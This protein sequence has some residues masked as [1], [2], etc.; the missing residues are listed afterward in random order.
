MKITVR[1]LQ[2]K[3][4]VSPKEI[5]KIILNVLLFERIKKR[6]EITVCIVEDKKI[7]ELNRKFLGKNEAT[8]VLAFDGSASSF[9]SARDGPSVPRHIS[10]DIVISTDTALRNAKAF[11]T[12]ASKEIKLY[13][14]HGILH[15]LGYDDHSPKDKK[16]MRDKEKKY[17]NR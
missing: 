11:R 4:P 17:V 12:N 13:L 9:G 5:K 7:K 1:N 6:A 10:A 14:I 16:L 3:I 2:K 8:D 15:L